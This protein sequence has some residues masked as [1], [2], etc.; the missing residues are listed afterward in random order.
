[1]GKA[2]GRTLCDDKSLQLQGALSL[3]CLKSFLYIICGH[4][5]SVKLSLLK[6]VCVGIL[7][8]SLFSY[9]IVIYAFVFY[10]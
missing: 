2:C 6:T 9:Y 1:M 10:V 7:Q 3:L 8:F 5:C 4:L